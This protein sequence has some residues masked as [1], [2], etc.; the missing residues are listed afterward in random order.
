VK[1]G[2]L[3]IIGLAFA[4]WAMMSLGPAHAQTLCPTT[5]VN[6]S[7][8]VAPYTWTKVGPNSSIE[9]QVTCNTGDT[10]TGG[11]LEVQQV[12]LPPSTI[13]TTPE[14]SFLFSDTTPTGWQVV[15]QDTNLDPVC[16]LKPKLAKC[17]IQFRVCVGCLSTTCSQGLIGG[18]SSGGL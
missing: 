4:L 14:N 10:A 5:Y 17:A 16:I 2:K 8:G 7:T 11:G 9:Q 3:L 18:S 12:P 6:C 1:F 15:V 13:V